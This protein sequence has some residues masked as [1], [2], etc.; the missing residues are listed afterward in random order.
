MLHKFL[1]FVGIVDVLLD[2]VGVHDAHRLVQRHDVDLLE[3]LDAD[4][5]VLV[6]DVFHIMLKEKQRF[7]L[8]EN[9]QDIQ[10][11]KTVTESLCPFTAF[12]FMISLS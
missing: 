3:P 7:V 2:S 12:N 8:K 4:V 9:Y 6:P 10:M 1:E 11:V 5:T